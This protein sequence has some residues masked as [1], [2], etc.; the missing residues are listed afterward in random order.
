MPLLERAR[1]E[2]YLPALPSA[3]YYNLLN[4][5]TRELTNTF[6]GHTINHALNEAGPAEKILIPTAILPTDAKD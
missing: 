6:G 3:A 2:I 1:L 4:E 5:L